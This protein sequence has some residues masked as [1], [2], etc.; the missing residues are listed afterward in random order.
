MSGAGTLAGDDRIS[1]WSRMAREKLVETAQSYHAMITYTELAEYVQD[2]SGVH[3]GQLM[4]YWIG[5]VL[6]RIAEDCGRRA[7]PMLSALCVTQQGAVGGGYVGAV[8]SVYGYEPQQPDDHA[9][10]QRFQCYRHFG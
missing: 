8:Q 1:V 4:R 9:A 10:E 5:D 7:E 3:T 6:F 2:A